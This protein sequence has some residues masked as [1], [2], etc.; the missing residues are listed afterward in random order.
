MVFLP[1]F[2]FYSMETEIYFI[3]SGLIYLFLK[4]SEISFTTDDYVCKIFSIYDGESPFVFM[5]RGL[6]L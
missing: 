6:K 2:Y 1:V 5:G 4:L 3:F